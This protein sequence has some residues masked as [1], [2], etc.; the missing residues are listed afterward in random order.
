MAVF[1]KKQCDHHI[2]KIINL[3]TNI[4]KIN[5]SEFNLV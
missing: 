1:E 5:Y 4:Q 2:I 3:T